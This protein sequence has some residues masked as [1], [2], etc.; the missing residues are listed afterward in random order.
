MNQAI[1]VMDSGV[2]GLTVV[3]EVLKQLPQEQVLYFG[4]TARA[5]YG[6]R[7]PEEVVRFTREIAEYLSRYQPKM[8]VLAC[9]TA[10]AVALDDIRSRVDIPVV[11]VIKP[12]ARAA[13]KASR[14]GRIGV[15]G[16]EGTIR[17][18][19]YD[20]AL[21]EISSQLEIVSLACPDLV[22]L[23]EAG[24]FDSPHAWETVRRSLAPLVGRELDSLIM[25]C[26][27]Y[28]FLTASI[29]E[30][31][32][33]KVEL[34]SSA[35]ETVREIGTILSY[36]G[37]LAKPKSESPLHRFFC[38]G[39]PVLFRRITSAWLE[40]QVEASSIVWQVQTTC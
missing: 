5:P 36:N 18:G 4:D 31:V 26:T 9:N 32:G 24:D 25:G 37:K 22:P 30:T 2:G 20:E 11:G 15:I 12:G 17:S 8:I 13:V 23:V 34:I 21:R 16:T 29:A 1:A 10:T 27:H 38:S 28:P 35:E 3:K 7:D 19:A 6:P 39:D 14:S 40:K 33:H